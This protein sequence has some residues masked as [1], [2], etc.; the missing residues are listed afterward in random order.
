MRSERSIGGRSSTYLSRTS[1]DSSSIEPRSSCLSRFRS[2]IESFLRHLARQFNVDRNEFWRLKEDFLQAVLGIAATD[3]TPLTVYQHLRNSLHN[4][5]I[6]YN[7]KYPDLAFNIGGY[8]FTFKHGKTVMI[9][10]EHIR[11]LQLANSTLLRTI[12]E[13]PKVTLLPEFEAHNIVVLHDDQ[14]A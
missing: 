13:H 5:G 4:K 7:A 1:P 2:T 12:C 11:Q 6:H 3:L 10:W 8:P 14:E 9:S